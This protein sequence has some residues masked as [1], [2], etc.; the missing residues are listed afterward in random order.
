MAF[1]D[2]TLHS[3][4]ITPMSSS[5]LPFWIYHY[6][7]RFDWHQT[8]SQVVISV[9]TK[10]VIAEESYVQANGTNVSRP[11]GMIMCMYKAIVQGEIR[12]TIAHG[13]NR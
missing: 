2:N 11:T 10:C 8:G 3:V 6:V 7:F 5:S 13:S 1:L 9:Y 4:P 12:I